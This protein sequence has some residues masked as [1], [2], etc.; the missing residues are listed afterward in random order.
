MAITSRILM[1]VMVTEVR[2][3]CHLEGPMR[4]LLVI[5]IGVGAAHADTL[6]LGDGRQ[7]KGK[8]L[9]ETADTYFV[10]VGF[11]VM[12]VP[13]KSVLA[14]EQDEKTQTKVGDARRSNDL[15]STKGREEASVKEKARRVIGWASRE[16]ALRARAEREMGRAT[17]T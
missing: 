6:R 11:T 15:F 17:A 4:L 13:K 5:L 16:K 8:I 3:G 10:D 7:V 12:S 9:K 1:A 2:I 14:R